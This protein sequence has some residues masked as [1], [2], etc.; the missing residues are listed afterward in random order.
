MS[1]IKFLREQIERAKRF[2]SG[3]TNSVDRERFEA[4]ADGY[5]RE[6]DTLSSP[7]AKSTDTP[8]PS[9][10]VAKPT[11]PDAAVPSEPIAAT[12]TGDPI[13]S[14]DTGQQETD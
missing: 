12:D 1:R 3:L 2:A 13:T 7:D 4:A 8:P 9:D 14:G 6:L 11:A 10:A 5:Q